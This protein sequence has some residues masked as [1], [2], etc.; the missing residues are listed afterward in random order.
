MPIVSCLGGGYG[1]HLLTIRFP[2]RV[3]QVLEHFVPI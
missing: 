1:V 2:Q 3:K